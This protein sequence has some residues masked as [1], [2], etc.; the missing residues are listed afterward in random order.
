MSF[1]RNQYFDSYEDVKD[2]SET[3]G[4]ELHH[5]IDVF[6]DPAYQQIL[7]PNHAGKCLLANYYKDKYGIDIFILSNRDDLRICIDQLRQYQGHV[8]VGF[9]VNATSQESGHVTPIVYEKKGDEESVISFDTNG[10]KGMYGFGI[11]KIGEIVN[12]DRVPKINLYA[13]DVLDAS[14]MS[15]SRQIDL[16]SCVNDAF[17]VLKDVLREKNV[18]AIVKEQSKKPFKTS[19]KGY[20]PFLLA[21]EWS[22]T[23]QREKYFDAKAGT[24]PDPKKKLRSNKIQSGKEKKT[25]T[26][27]KM[28]EKHS[29]ELTMHQLRV[30]PT[31]DK[32]GNMIEK[33]GEIVKTK[34]SKINIYLKKKGF[35]NAK[36]VKQQ[37]EEHKDH[38]DFI[39]WERAAGILLSEGK[40]ELKNKEE[41]AK[42]SDGH[43]PSSKFKP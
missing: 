14:A 16:R 8:K 36:R 33:R 43:S 35:S 30:H 22:K 7:V 38:L 11:D 9:I 10:P 34:K 13:N 31:I 6:A 24:N 1:N 3:V 20:T 41:K 19:P 32:K 26:F 5:K 29:T 15:P 23:V 37:F 17:V 27:K 18:T 42:Q 25:E 40:S 39:C 2:S 12:K 28:R 4:N 21:E